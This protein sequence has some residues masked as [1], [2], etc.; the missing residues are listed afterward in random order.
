MTAVTLT[1][2]AYLDAVWTDITSDTIASA[3]SEWGM[4]SNKPLDLLAKTG[5][6]RFSLKNSTGKY[7]P[8]G[9][10][11]VATDWGKGTKVKAV[12]TYDSQTYV[13]FYGA[14]DKLELDPGTLGER[15]VHVTALDWM[16]YAAKYPIQNPA[17]ELNKRADEAITTLLAGMP[18]QPSVT[19]LDTGANTF[20]TVFNDATLKT[21]AYSEFQKLVLSEFGRIYHLKD[22]TYGDT[23]RF[24]SA[25][26]RAY[27]T[28]VKQVPVNTS[29][30]FILMETGDR[31]LM[32][33]GDKI[34]IESYALQDVSLN[35]TMI[36]MDVS[37]GENLINR[38][39]VS[40]NPTRI[41][42]KDTALFALDSALFVDAGDTKEFFVQFTESSSK[43]LVAALA[44]D[45]SYP[46]TLLH[47]DAPGPEEVV[48]DEAGKPF[49]DY[50]VS[51]IT[52]TKKVGVAS[53]YLDGSASYA[54]GT[55]SDDYEFG[56]GDFTVEWWEYRFNADASEAVVCRGGGGGYVS[57]IL[58]SSDGT[59]SLI[60]IT[61]NG[62]SWDIANGKTFGAI[63]LN[64]WVHYALVRSGSN[65]IAYKDGTITDTWTSSA[66]ILASTDA[67]TIGK[68]AGYYITACLDEIRITKGYAR[69]NA[70]FT[71]TTE[72]FQLSGL[73]KGAWTNAN[74]TGTELTEDFEISISYGAAGAT[75]T[76][77]N[78]GTTGGYLTTL[79][80]NGKIVETVSPVTDIQEN[81]ASIAAYGYHE[82]SIDQKYQQDFTSGRE[83]AAA[84]L[85]AE[86]FP[87]V[88]INRVTFNANRDETHMQ[89]F[90]RT[91]VGDLVNI[92]EDQTETDADYYIQSMGWDATAGSSGAI[93]NAWWGVKKFRDTPV[94]LAI[95]FS[96][97]TDNYNHVEWGYLPQIAVENVPYRV[98]SLWFN[99]QSTMAQSGELITCFQSGGDSSLQQGYSISFTGVGR[100]MR[101]L[102]QSGS[103]R[104]YWDS[105]ALSNSVGSW[106]HVLLA[107]D[108][109]STVNQPTLYVNGVANTMTLQN[110]Y[111]TT[112]SGEVG[113]NLKTNIS[114]TTISVDT[115]QDVIMKDIR[116]YNGDQVADPAALA[117]ALYA[118]TPYG[119]ANT[120]GLLFRAF[121]ADP[122]ELAEYEGAYLTEAQKLIDDIGFAVGTPKSSPLG[123]AL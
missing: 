23:L 6:L 58:G 86:R 54:E 12:F 113:T 2:Y 97:L 24:E 101:F 104:L 59:N 93:V 35:N 115:Y 80:I 47:F 4:S 39:T 50:D 75:V 106:F 116:V 107:Y 15:K 114:S 105:T 5:Q 65:F 96:D 14:I 119:N 20:P 22:K 89:Y 43:R 40:A 123:V 69:Y 62:S 82:L 73:I 110:S 67:L 66:T 85:D 37:Y 30:G 33:T 61:S 117:A 68:N 78:S 45:T 64:T 63:A 99:S 25:N 52:T 31:I 34:L 81:A 118:E 27:S 77:V 71:P 7:I 16:D 48:V 98:W 90:L 112:R 10:A 60:Y 109:R 42:T 88:E 8:S 36:D 100:K 121:N 57:W 21:K 1:I 32:E 38:I 103:T 28:P 13:R 111:S 94:P 102:G 74:G 122:S 44:P 17:I 41:D 87:R 11:V 79:K 92:V 18:I 51:L 108:S 49:D 9:A 83:K 76:V 53:M 3:S 56:S 120:T 26:A 29:S 95:H 70:A 46:T 72:P 55:S 19:T 91:D 84:I